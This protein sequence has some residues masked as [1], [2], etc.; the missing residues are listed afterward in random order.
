MSAFVVSNTH[1]NAIVNFT[2]VASPAFKL[3]GY[4]F[5]DEYREW[6]SPE[7]L[8]QIL[9]DEN[10]RSV[11]ARYGEHD[12]PDTFVFTRTLKPIS[13]VAMLS[14]LDCLEYQSCESYDWV[15][16]LAHCL[17]EVMRSWTIHR[18]PGYAEAAWEIRDGPHL[19]PRRPLS[20]AP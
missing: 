10:V 18:L 11:N 20:P 16:T 3:H 15:D 13:A 7:Q 9:L 5:Q 19:K 17:V 4:S 14:A 12:E 8:G 2:L 6:P 1:I